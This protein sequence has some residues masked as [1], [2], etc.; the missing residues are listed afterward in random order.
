MP[1]YYEFSTLSIVNITLRSFVFVAGFVVLILSFGKGNVRSR[2][3]LNGSSWFRGTLGLFLLAVLLNIVA[4]VISHIDP[5]SLPRD[6]RKHLLRFPPVAIFFQAQAFAT[7]TMVQIEAAAGLRQ[8]GASDE[9]AS[10]GAARVWGLVVFFVF[11]ILN[12]AKLADHQGQISNMLNSA[13]STYGIESMLVLDFIVYLLLCLGA[14]A[15]LIYTL[16]VRQVALRTVFFSLA[17]AAFASFARSMWDVVISGIYSLGVMNKHYSEYPEIPEGIS[18]GE[19]IMQF[20]VP[21]VAFVLILVAWRKQQSSHAYD[22][23]SQDVIQT[24]A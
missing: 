21:L 10:G 24:F 8:Q 16:N 2:I 1:E 13:T 6:E 12:I 17:V 18:V 3:S 5:Y 7:M 20:L 23:T 14:F 11:T 19:S 9:K 4:V 22:K 15:V